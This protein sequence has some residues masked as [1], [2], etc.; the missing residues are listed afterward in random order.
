MKKEFRA[1][2]GHWREAGGKAESGSEARV[3]SG[4]VQQR[5]TERERGQ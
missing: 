3:G 2:E 1:G 4:C 5:V